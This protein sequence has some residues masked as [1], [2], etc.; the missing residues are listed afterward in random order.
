MNLELFIK[1]L[2]KE[3]KECEQNEWD[4][5]SDALKDYYDITNKKEISEIA[6]I[7]T[8]GTDQSIAWSAG[9]CFAMRQILSKIEDEGKKNK[10]F[11]WVCKSDPCHC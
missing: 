9:Y 7:E 11:C 2:K 5:N 1:W 10:D 4:A 6:D 3:K 8:E